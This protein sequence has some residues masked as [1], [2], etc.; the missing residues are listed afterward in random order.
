MTNVADTI[1]NPS[2]PQIGEY[3]QTG[4]CD[5]VDPS[6]VFLVDPSGDQIVDTGVTFTSIDDTIWAA[7][8]GS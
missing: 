6:D 8:D 3:S 4:V 5:I 7:S 1:W 2:N